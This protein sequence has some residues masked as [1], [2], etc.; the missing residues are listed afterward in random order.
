MSCERWQ[1]IACFAPLDVRC[2]VIFARAV[3]I[4]VALPVSV[5]LAAQDSLVAG[6]PAGATTELLATAVGQAARRDGIVAVGRVLYCDATSAALDSASVQACIALTEANATRLVGAFAHAL[7]RPLLEQWPT[8]TADYPACEDDGARGQRGSLAVA[9]IGAPV[10]GDREGRWE[11]RITVELSCRQPNG[12]GPPF[13]RVLA[14]EFLFQW[15]GHAWT[16]YQVG[17]R[18]VTG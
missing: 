12:G 2:D 7:G 15:D 17:T 3:F 11:G 8:T 6:Q 10:V 14:R 18:R 9:R 1:A 13:L 5:P 16:F 4:L